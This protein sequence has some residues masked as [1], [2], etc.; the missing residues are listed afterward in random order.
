MADKLFDTDKLKKAVEA[1]KP[2]SA[3]Q[4]DDAMQKKLE[5]VWHEIFEIFRRTLKPPEAFVLLCLMKQ[6]MQDDYGFE[7]VVFVEGSGSTQ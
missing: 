2:I 7:D 1:N 6:E 5:P 3:F 4:Y